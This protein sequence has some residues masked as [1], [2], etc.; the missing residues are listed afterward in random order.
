MVQL[1]SLLKAVTP[2]GKKKIFKNPYL[3]EGWL[4]WYVYSVA[5]SSNLAIRASYECSKGFLY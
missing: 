1:L 2:S 3:M 5:V 4:I